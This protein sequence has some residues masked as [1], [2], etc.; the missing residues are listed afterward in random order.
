M[1]MLMERSKQK[2]FPTV[3]AFNTFFFTKL[4]T[5]GYAAVKRWTKKVD[6]FSVDILLVPVHLG[7]HWC[8][9]VSIFDVCKHLH[10]ERQRHMHASL[11]DSSSCL[12]TLHSFFRIVPLIL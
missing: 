3:H 10:I 11:S 7:V 1:N 4:K 5:A 6:I 12:C 9:A 8:L 2:G